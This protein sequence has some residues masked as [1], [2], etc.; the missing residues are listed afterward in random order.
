MNLIRYNI[1]R[2]LRY[3]LK[4]RS[5]TA[6]SLVGLVIGL[7]C[8]FIISAWTFQELRFDR[9]HHEADHI[10]MVTTDIKDNAGNVNRFPETPPP[11]AEALEEQIPQIEK[12]FHFLYLYGGRSLEANEISFKEEGIAAS[13][14]FL[15]VLNFRLISGIAKEL[16][17]LNSIYL[18]QSLAAKL[19]PGVDP[20]RKEVLYRDSMVLVVKGIFKDVPRNSS[21]QFDFLI[22]Y[23]IE[24]G[25]SD[26]WRQLSDATFIKTSPS[27]DMEKV[28]LLMKEI[29]SERITDDQYNIGII[30]IT[31]L[32][33]DADF[34]FFNAEHGHGSRK[35]LYMFLG[36]AM[37]ILI[38][39]CLN[40][41][42][43][44]S[45][46]A[47]KRDNDIWIR[48]VH[49]ASA[50]NITN[51]FMIESVFLSIFAWGLATLLSL[52]GIRVFEKL[53]GIVISS[54]YFYIS[55]GIGFITAII[56]VGLASG[57]YPAI[58]AG[59]G[60]LVKSNDSRKPDF[61]FQARLRN[62]FVVSQFVLSI[63][64]TVSSLIII[65]QA[66]FMMKFETGYAKQ[67]IVDFYLPVNDDQALHH[68]KNWLNANPNVEG[69]SFGSKAP[70]NLTFLN[71]MEKWRWEGLEEEAHTSFYR[72]TADEEYL[73][74]FEIPLTEG[75]FFSSLATDQNQIVIN[76]TLAG[77]TE[78]E[79]PVGQIIRRGENEY[80]IIGVVRDFNFQHLSNEIRPLLF[81]N[82]GSKK[83]LFVKIKSNTEETVKQ[84]QEQI[85]E[86]SDNP[87]NYS[88]I[89]DEHDELYKGEQ[90]ILSAILIFTL[91]SILLSSLGLIGLVTYNTETKTKEIAIRKVFGSE[92][93]EMMITLNLNIL[94]MFLPSMILGCFI[95]WLIMRGWIADYVYRRGLEGWVFLIGSIII[96]VVALLSVSIQTWKA[97]KQSP[98]VALKT[99]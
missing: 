4:F 91:L 79:N 41:M 92:T 45:A 87:V 44:I 66:D 2:A 28:H 76:E 74:V 19:Y 63:A 29:W 65:R 90:Q 67:D 20:L 70:V 3:I 8:V 95:A 30:P 77:L 96:L 82:N 40:Y 85:S 68:I 14:E 51:Y 72:L 31:D 6:F 9:F 81:M 97:A 25:I 88:F 39:A 10:Y 5:H 17:E 27:A 80:E 62:G 11:L 35:K 46:Y 21:L 84:I 89:I 93:R 52:L 24:Y 18:S 1:I 98:A 49:G 86:L 12:G 50:G 42:N 48:K 23:E 13:P 36:V 22:P 78:Y 61:M 99:Q 16:D 83:H 26:E 32:R 15:E 55:V 57:L 94:R 53:M 60:V 71:T 75:R 38:L 7:A 56:I 73:N 34:E 59:S 33:Y 43:L 64:L 47:I 69:Y 58:R 54:T 37:M